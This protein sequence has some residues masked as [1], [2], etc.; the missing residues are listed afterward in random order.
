[1]E[2]WTRLRDWVVQD[3]GF[4]LNGGH[5]QQR[6]FIR[7][8]EFPAGLRVRFAREHPQLSLAQRDDVFRALKQYFLVC[9]HLNGT[10]AAMPSQIVDEAWHGFILFTREYNDFSRRA[11]G[12]YLHHTPAEA[13]STPTR[14]TDAIKRTWRVACRIEKID[15][16]QPDRLPLLFATDAA[17]KIPNGFTYHLDCM[18]GATKTTLNSNRND[19]CATHIGCGGGDCG[20]GAGCASCGGSSCG[21]S[22]CGGGC[23]GD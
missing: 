10:M 6:E 7:R 20:D 18:A 2:I 15:P 17:L 19:F 8:Y 4:R 14:A 22:G 1:M 23:G 3:G 5:R 13:M 16:L 12:R 9:H 11:F 21:G